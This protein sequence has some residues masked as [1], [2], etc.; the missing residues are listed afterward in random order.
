[1]RFFR[2]SHFVFGGWWNV[3]FFIF[4]F[5]IRSVYP[6]L[7]IEVEVEFLLSITMCPLGAPRPPATKISSRFCVKNSLS[8]FFIF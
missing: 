6:D 8:I 2:G 7:P 4:F 5:G 1:M 3:D